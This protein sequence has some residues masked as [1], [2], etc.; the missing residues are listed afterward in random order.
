MFPGKRLELLREVVPGL[1][2]VAILANA[3]F[4]T[5]ALEVSE[6]QA[7]ARILGLEAVTLEIQRAEDIAPSLETIKDRAE[8]LLVASSPLLN[9]NRTRINTLAL[10]ARLPT[11]HRFSGVR[12]NRRSDVLWTKLP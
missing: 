7:A 2:R 6:V 11:I 9:T 3:G 1:H 10:A 12:R 5:N 4:R 8:A